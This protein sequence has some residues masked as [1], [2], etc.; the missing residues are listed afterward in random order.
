MDELVRAI[1]DAADPADART[2]A[3][4]FQVRPGGYGEGDVFVGVKLSALRRLAV[5]YLREPFVPDRWLPLLCSPVHEHRLIALVVMNER[6]RRSAG[7]RGNADELALVCRCYLAHT[8]YVNNWDLVDVSC[9]AIVGGYLQHRD[10]APLYA[11]ANSSS[12]WDRR[13]AIVGAQHFLKSGD[14]SDVFALAEVLLADSHDLIHKAVGWSLREAGRRDRPALR[15]FLD[16]HAATMPRTALRY[17][18]EH[19]DPEKRSHYM[20]RAR[21]LRN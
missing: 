13:I 1:A 9:R 3:R 21:A 19:F 18:I 16:Q 4:Y 11:L 6:A 12:M 14:C 20:G 5:P 8:A 15:R 17:A 7:P 2:L 10:R